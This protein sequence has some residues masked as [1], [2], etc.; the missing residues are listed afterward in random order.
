MTVASTTTCHSSPAT[1]QSTPEH[2]TLLVSP[3]VTFPLKDINLFLYP[4]PYQTNSWAHQ[5]ASG[6]CLNFISLPGLPQ[7]LQ[8]LGQHSYS[9]CQLLQLHGNTLLMRLS[10]FTTIHTPAWTCSLWC[11]SL[12]LS[13]IFP[14]L[15]SLCQHHT[16]Y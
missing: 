10:V 7:L 13:Q 11:Y 4:P 14:L 2:I 3:A 12:K 16:L 8:L 9:S 15:K 1:H 6:N 5:S